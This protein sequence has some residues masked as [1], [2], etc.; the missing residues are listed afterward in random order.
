MRYRNNICRA[1]DGQRQVGLGL[2]QFLPRR[3]VPQ[4]H[5]QG[6]HKPFVVRRVAVVVVLGQVLHGILLGLWLPLPLTQTLLATFTGGILLVPFTYLIYEYLK[7]QH[8][9]NDRILM[10]GMSGN[11]T[12][13][14]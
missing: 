11:P 5:L 7:Q 10:N 1:R 13:L 12:S 2:E 3:A 14:A 4:G 9:R 8:I 6:P